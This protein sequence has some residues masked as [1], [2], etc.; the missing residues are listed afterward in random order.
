MVPMLRRLSHHLFTAAAAASL[1]LCVATVVM[2]ARSYWRADLVIRNPGR[3]DEYCLYSE[4]GMVSAKR[5][6]YDRASGRFYVDSTSPKFFFPY[7]L[8]AIALAI[9]PALWVL[10]LRPVHRRRRM[11]LGLCPSCGYDLRATPGRCPEC[12]TIVTRK[13][14][15]AARTVVEPDSY[16]KA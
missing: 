15:G 14:G 6:H 2:W 9:P 7:A 8:P 12:G 16:N 10:T 1:V 5:G 13:P 3:P 11:S 4:G